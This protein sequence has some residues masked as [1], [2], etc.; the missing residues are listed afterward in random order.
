MK[1]SISARLLW[2]HEPPMF[3][4]E[5][6][7]RVDEYRAACQR[8]TSVATPPRRYRRTVLTSDRRR[9][10]GVGIQ[11]KDV[12]QRPYQANEGGEWPPFPAVSNSYVLSS[13][14]IL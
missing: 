14:W 3:S 9:W 5:R 10:A 4:G 12:R 13:R 6:V 11:C 1:S 8:L 7:C 2:I